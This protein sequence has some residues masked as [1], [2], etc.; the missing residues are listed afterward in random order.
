MLESQKLVGSG[1]AQPCGSCTYA[2]NPSVHKNYTNKRCSHEEITP[3][4][5]VSVN[6]NVTSVTVGIKFHL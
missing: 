1:P 5:N 2:D 6:V 3:A 4:E